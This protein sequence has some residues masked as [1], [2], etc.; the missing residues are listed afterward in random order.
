MKNENILPGQLV[1]KEIRHE[2]Y[3]EALKIV[4]NFN[5]NY[6][7]TDPHLCLLLPCILWQL[8]NY[9]YATPCGELID[10]TETEN[11]FPEIRDIA[12]DIECLELYQSQRKKQIRI[13]YLTNA[14][15]ATQP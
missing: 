10:Y 11:M 4:K 6:G 15:N 2:V 5:R 9:I 7:L 14:I 13:Q 8:E 3:K 12:K 1:P